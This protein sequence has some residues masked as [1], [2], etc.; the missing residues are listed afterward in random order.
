MRL[1]RLWARM[2][3]LR[4]GDWRA[5]L[6]TLAQLSVAFVAV[7]A[8]IGMFTLNPFWLL[9]FTLVQALL[10]FGTVLYITVVIFAQRAMVEE[11]F[12]AGEI[13]FREG[14][15]GQHLYVIKSGKV[16]VLATTRG[17]LRRIKELGPGEHFGEMALLGNHPRTATVRTL[18]PVALMK[19]A[20]GPF[21]SIYTSL[22]GVQEHFNA[23]VQARLQELKVLK[24][25]TVIMMKPLIPQK[26][27]PKP[28]TPPLPITPP[29]L[30]GSP[31]RFFPRP[32]NWPT[33]PMSQA[34]VHTPTA[35]V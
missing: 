6:I 17:V 2:P 19:M 10:G 21:A 30:D 18:T 24:A 27:P 33:K 12:G 16:E 15:F 32:A 23:I 31:R 35:R 9:G 8:L 4:L 22:P 29:P 28:V 7:V 34:S 1:N 3:E 20:R 13:I 14:E 26:S 11:D 5:K 25:D